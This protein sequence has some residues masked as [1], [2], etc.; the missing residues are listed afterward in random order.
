[1]SILFK[2]KEHPLSN[3]YIIENQIEYKNT[4]FNSIEQAYQWEKAVTHKQY[5]IANKIKETQNPF[6]QMSLG[7]L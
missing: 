1:M 6:K 4:S 5:S 2:G 3:L 7:K